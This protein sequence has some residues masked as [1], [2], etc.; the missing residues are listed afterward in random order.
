[1]SEPFVG[2]IRIFTYTYAPRFWAFC[3][4][5]TVPI[6]EFTAL[7]AVISDSF[8]GDAR[9]AMG[10]P[11]LKGRAPTHLGQSPGLS[12][13]IYAHTYGY[14]SVALGIS[15]LP[16]H[17]HVAYGA[18]ARGALPD[19]ENAYTAVDAGST[20]TLYGLAND[21]SE[22]HYMDSATIDPAGGSEPHENMQPYLVLPYCIALEGIFPSRN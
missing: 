19:G 16:A 14:S 22:A 11:N 5:Q 1:M 7:Y 9:Q 21:I 13:Y 8:G 17:T 10:L 15:D 2:E 4:G 6:A 12:K 18:R 3:D 20:G